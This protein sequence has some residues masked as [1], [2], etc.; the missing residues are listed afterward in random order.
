MKSFVG[1]KVLLTR[2]V[3][4]NLEL[5]RMLNNLE[6]QVE[7]L[8]L[9]EILPNFS[10]V[11]LNALES[12]MPEF[13]GFIFISV[14]AAI[15]GVN[16]LQQNQSALK[17]DSKII[18]VGPRTAKEL[19]A[20]FSSV[21]CP[22][23]GVGA[24]S[25]L[26]THEMLDVADLK[27]LILRGRNGNPWLGKELQNRQ[28]IVEYYDCYSRR[29]PRHLEK[30]LAN[31]FTEKVFD[32]CFLHSAHAAINLVESSGRLGQKISNAAAVVGSRAIR[33]ALIDYGWKGDIAVARTPANTDMLKCLVTSGIVSS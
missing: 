7:S 9:I 24:Q 32:V 18:A 5:D 10:R 19:N 25:L 22:E 15:Y 2:S 1:K 14:N 3:D 31:L 13:D 21:L 33:D 30:E 17:Q 11:R 28:A 12:M 26:A 29:R 8:P 4:E 27:F 16:L 23:D 20:V 6:F